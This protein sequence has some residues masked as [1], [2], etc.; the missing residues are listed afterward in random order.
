MSSLFW[1]FKIVIACLYIQSTGPPVQQ[2][3]TCT[4]SG[5]SDI[6]I[7]CPRKKKS[8]KIIQIQ[9]KNTH[10]LIGQSEINSICW[11]YFSGIGVNPGEGQGKTSPSC[12][13]MRG[14]QYQMS[15][16]LIGQTPFKWYLMFQISF[17]T[18]CSAA[19]SFQ[20]KRNSLKYWKSN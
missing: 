11:W 3:G 1:I 7:F 13:A 15:C 19:V 2:P 9:I 14:T 16:S 6:P 5:R 17:K 4:D 20:N 10:K 12:V 8:K 18:F